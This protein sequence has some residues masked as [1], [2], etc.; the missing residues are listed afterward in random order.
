MN[1][2]LAAEGDGLA[3]FLREEV[4]A[5]EERRDVDGDD[6]DRSYV[7]CICGAPRAFWLNVNFDASAAR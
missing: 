4:E 3:E 1:N 6:V 7:T 5:A 2:Y